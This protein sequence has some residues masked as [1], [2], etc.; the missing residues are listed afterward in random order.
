VNW[1]LTWLEGKNESDEFELRGVLDWK[2]DAPLF[3][4]K[5]VSGGMVRLL[6]F[7]INTKAERNDLFSLDDA[8]SGAQKRLDEWLRAVREDAVS[9]VFNQLDLRASLMVADGQWHQGTALAM[10]E[11][12]ATI[13]R[14]AFPSLELSPD[15][16]KVAEGLPDAL[17]GTRSA[18]GLQTALEFVERIC[19]E[20]KRDA[21][22][23]R[24][25]VTVEMLFTWAQS[26]LG[27]AWE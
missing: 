25:G 22:R 3:I 17:F 23:S 27:R 9:S 12:L 19:A 2:P 26:Y 21:R 18:N 7:C 14:V 15:K 10:L 13:G 6:G 20:A 8:R 24:D 1:Q 11:H 16:T 5:P 4:I